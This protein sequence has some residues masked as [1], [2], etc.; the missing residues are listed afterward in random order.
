[1][2]IIEKQTWDHHTTI[3]LIY[4]AGDK[5]I[6]S[7]SL[8]TGYNDFNEIQSLY[9]QPEFRGIGYSKIMVEDILVFAKENG[10]PI[11]LIVNKDNEIAIN[12]YEKN[13][14]KYYKDY[15]EEFNWMKLT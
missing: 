10:D 5:L 4:L 14:F 8:Q 3:R 2:R 13:G 12:L 9:I 7:V 1:M 6:G 11:Y 15:N